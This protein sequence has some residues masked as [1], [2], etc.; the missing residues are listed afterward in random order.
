M[1]TVAALSGA[2]R[3]SALVR[4]QG[5]SSGLMPV[6]CPPCLPHS[7]PP[8]LSDARFLP[9]PGSPF[10]RTS[11]CWAWRPWGLSWTRCGFGEL[12]CIMGTT[13][14]TLWHLW[15]LVGWISPDPLLWPPNPVFLIQPAALGQCPWLPVPSHG[16]PRRHLRWSSAAATPEGSAGSTAGWALQGKAPLP[17]APVPPVC[18]TGWCVRETNVGVI[19]QG[20]AMRRS[21]RAVGASRGLLAPQSCWLS[22]QCCPQCGL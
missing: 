15:L 16:W 12:L 19:E 2:N 13:S 6:S 14:L 8:S 17:C 1:P 21:P 4:Q 10:C 7:C 18:Q 3:D 11:W 5:W 20:T 22:K 9:L